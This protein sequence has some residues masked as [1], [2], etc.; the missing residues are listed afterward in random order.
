VEEHGPLRLF[1]REGPGWAYYA[2]PVP[3]G[4]AVPAAR[5]V[6]AVRA[7]QRELGL[8]EAFEWVHECVPELLDVAR[9]AGLQVLEAPLMVLRE[10]GRRTPEPPPGVTVRLLEPGDPALAAAYGIARVAFSRPGTARGGD[11]PA[12]RDAVAAAQS[13]DERA[14]TSDRLR[15]GLTAMAVAEEAAEGPLAAGSH[16]P[17]GDV[18]EVTGIGTLPSARR[19]G[20]GALVTWRLV[21]D[22]RERGAELVFI[23]A[24]SEEIARVYGRLGFE[25]IGTSCIAEPG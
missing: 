2:R 24:G 21:Q 14:F 17:L 23:S 11:G 9:A 22:A 13:A 8:P 19:R 25:R 3:G 7:R 4:E 18:T 12:A 15:R 16:Q 20:L 6:E 10:E 1:V 5:D